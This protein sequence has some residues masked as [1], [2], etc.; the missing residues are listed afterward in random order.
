M[1][2][3][4]ILPFRPKKLIS[5]WDMIRFFA[6]EA[7]NMLER[8][9]N[10]L[11]DATE[12]VRNKGISSKISQDDCLELLKDLGEVKSFCK[13]YELEHSF[14]RLAVFTHKFS[15]ETLINK[16]IES[17]LDGLIITLREELN[18]RYC[19]YIPKGKIKY[20]ENEMLFGPQVNWAF[21]ETAQDIKD[22]GNCI[23]A[24][25]NTAAVFH[26]MRVIEYGLRALAASLRVK[27]AFRQ[28]IDEATWGQIIAQLESKI[29]DIKPH[30]KAKIK[31]HKNKKNYEFYRN[32]LIE[33]SHF[34][35][36]WRNDVMHTRAYYNQEQALGLL[37]RVK[38]FTNSIVSHGVKKPSKKLAALFSSLK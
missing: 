16:V 24:D 4:S 23:A 17:E 1:K 3:D 33:C 28:P 36:H 14:E 13:K 21:P 30:P 6:T 15:R 18:N 20:F 19:A 38:D 10:H 32:M 2:A 11:L 8:L 27:V 22:A 5:L 25:L 35:N 34:K 26:L 12:K 9:N 7:T 31:N 29:P 37:K